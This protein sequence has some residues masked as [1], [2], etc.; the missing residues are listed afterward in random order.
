M[1]NELPATAGPVDTVDFSNVTV[2]RDVEGKLTAWCG[3]TKILGVVAMGISDNILNMALTMS[4]VRLAEGVPA[5]PVVQTKTGN[6][7]QFPKLRAVQAETD[8][9]QADGDTA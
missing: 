8:A 3:D 6:V 5:T 2:V 7:L 1:A 4:R 9:P